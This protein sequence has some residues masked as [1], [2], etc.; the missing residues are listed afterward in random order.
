ME[1][2]PKDNAGKS[3]KSKESFISHEDRPEVQISLDTPVSELKIRDL[4]SILR[5]ISG[6]HPNFENK[7]AMKE[8]FDKPFPEVVKDKEFKDKEIEKPPKEKNEKLEKHEKHEK[9]DKNEKNESKEF[10]VEKAENDG[11]YENRINSQ[12]SILIE[13]V[14]GLTKQVA[15]LTDQVDAIKKK[16]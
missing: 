6:K 3:E 14:A 4:A 9:S 12:M 1:K 7:T 11:I 15:N 10:K 5:T 13:S 2:S 8:F 16:G